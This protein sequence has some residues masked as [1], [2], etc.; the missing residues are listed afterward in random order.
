MTKEIFIAPSVV[1]RTISISFIFAQ[2]LSNTLFACKYDTIY[3]DKHL[4]SFTTHYP[5]LASL[6]S[7][8]IKETQES[9]TITLQ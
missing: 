4:S 8:E 9:N 6:S 1:E 2:P 5:S 3:K 7:H